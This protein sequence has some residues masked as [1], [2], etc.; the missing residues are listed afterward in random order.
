VA[1]ANCC[2]FFELS[3]A[4]K[5]QIYYAPWG[6]SPSFTTANLLIA[7]LS[8]MRKF[9]AQIFNPGQPAPYFYVGGLWPSHYHVCEF[10]AVVGFN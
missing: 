6:I 8:S 4:I 5:P 10:V 7:I 2:F 3:L 1:A 9:T